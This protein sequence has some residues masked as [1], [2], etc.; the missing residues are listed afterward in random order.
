MESHLA[1]K[2]DNAF[3]QRSE[4]KYVHAN[5]VHLELKDKKGFL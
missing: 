3:V 4:A 5:P 2:F 1:T